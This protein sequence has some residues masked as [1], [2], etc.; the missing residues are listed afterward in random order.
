MHSKTL[1][2]QTV[3]QFVAPLLYSDLQTSSMFHFFCGTQRFEL[4]YELKLI[5]GLTSCSDKK[6]VSSKANFTR[7]VIE[8]MKSKN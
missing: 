2:L 4:S 1:R 5:V 6:K 3:K 8:A 7:I